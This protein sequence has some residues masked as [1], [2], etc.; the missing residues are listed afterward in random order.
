MTLPTMLRQVLT[1]AGLRVPGA[2]ACGV[3]RALGNASSWGFLKLLGIFT[4]GAEG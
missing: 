1:S 2:G 4:R 3:G